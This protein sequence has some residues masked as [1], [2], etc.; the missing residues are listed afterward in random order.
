M[1]SANNPN[2]DTTGSHPDDNDVK[3]RRRRQTSAE[4]AA[5]REKRLRDQYGNSLL[6]PGEPPLHGLTAAAIQCAFALF[7]QAYRNREGCKPKSIADK[8]A[9]ICALPA[10]HR[11]LLLKW[12]IWAKPRRWVLREDGCSSV[13][14][15]A[16]TCPGRSAIWTAELDTWWRAAFEN[17]KAKKRV[18][19]APTSE[20]QALGGTVVAVPPATAVSIP[21]QEV[22]TQPDPK[23]ANRLDERM[24]RDLFP[25]DDTSR[26]T[27]SLEPADHLLNLAARTEP[28]SSSS[29]PASATVAIDRS[30]IGP[31]P[32]G[33]FV[34]GQQAGNKFAGAADEYLKG[35]GSADDLS[36]AAVAFS[37]DIAACRE[38]C[39]RSP[40]LRE[41]VESIFD[42]LGLEVP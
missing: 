10:E 1:S 28:N 42:Q 3:R 32:Y 14:A 17:P 36:K 31:L 5:R 27:S 40:K 41:L 34:K 18:D 39:E 38:F 8:V 19:K 16:N 23:L 24:S 13:V 33:A 22:T 26:R 12:L 4:K 2:T 20:T 21:P 29:S 9:R 15:W 30:K 25:R 37:K 35:S 7:R 6:D 11:E